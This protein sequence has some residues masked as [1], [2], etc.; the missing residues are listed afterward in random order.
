M[1][2]VTYHIM[3]P[4]KSSPNKHLYICCIYHIT[5]GILHGGKKEN[6]EFIEVRAY[7]L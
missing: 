4:H 6:S 1:V 2:C 5:I 7:C 3:H